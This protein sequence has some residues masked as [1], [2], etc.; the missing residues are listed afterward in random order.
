MQVTAR[1]EL[2]QPPLAEHEKPT[3]ETLAN[4][5]VRLRLCILG[6]MQ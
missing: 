1:P 4:D 2:F 5:P 3:P 6:C